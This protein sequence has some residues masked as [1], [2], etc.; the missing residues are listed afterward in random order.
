MMPKDGLSMSN[1]ELKISIPVMLR[2]DW[3]L[4]PT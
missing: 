3:I 2:F 1:T 4:W